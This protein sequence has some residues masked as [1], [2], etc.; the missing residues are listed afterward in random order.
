M[1]SKA[2]SDL[3][4]TEL[5]GKAGTV[6]IT[7]ALSNKEFV[8]IYFSAHWCPP[9]RAFTPVLVEKYKAAA[10]AKNIEVVFV[11][12]DRD[13]GGF[14]S[15]YAEMPWLT[16]PY[17]KKDLKNKLSEKY[18]V[19]GIPALVVLNAAGDLITT[20]GRAKVD[21]FFSGAQA[22]GGGSSSFEEMFPV[23]LLSKQGPVKVSEALAG[24]DKVMIYFSAHWCPPCRGFTPVLADKYKQSAKEKNIE[25][26]FVSSDRDQAS[27]QEYYNEMPWLSL[28]FAARDVK[29]RLSKLFGVSGI[30]ML[31]VLNSKG[32][33]LTKDGRG[34]VNTFF[35]GSG[36]SSGL[37]CNAM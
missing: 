1:V 37:G 35:G 15:Y 19:R 13:E 24:K 4:G 12:S 27:F 2:L 5:Q 31:V 34:Q 26:V 6:S 7:E 3:F 22:A 10:A 29:D 30:P 11:S 36:G 32:E 21:D 33:I 17:E 25:V 9:C 16:L 14:N 8:M 20:E 28:P 23:D 18:G